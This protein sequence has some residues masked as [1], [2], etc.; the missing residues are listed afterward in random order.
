MCEGRDVAGGLLSKSRRQ[1]GLRSS[2]VEQIDLPR[3]QSVI[4][5]HYLDAVLLHRILQYRFGFANLLGYAPCVCNHSAMD[6]VP[7]LLAGCLDRGL[8]GCH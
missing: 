7:W 4:R 6:S 3:I 2:R 5:R 1:L 8:N